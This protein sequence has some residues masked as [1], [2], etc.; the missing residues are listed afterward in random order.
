MKAKRNIFRS[1]DVFEWAMFIIVLFYSLSM[2]TVLFLGLLNSLKTYDDA[3]YYKNFFGL[4]NSKYGWQFQYYTTELFTMF[5]VQPSGSTEYVYMHQMLLNSLLYAVLMSLFTI[6][7]Q[8]MVAYAC[9]KFTFKLNKVLYTT[10]IITMIIPIV[11]SLASEMQVVEFL[12]LR[13][14]IL[15]VC[16]ARCRYSGMYFLVFYAM[17]KSVPWT[18]AEA[19]QIDGAGNLKI[20]LQVMLPL[21][22]STIFA[23]FVLQFINNW[24]DYYTPMLF[25]PQMPTIAY[26]LFVFKNYPEREAPT[27]FKLAASMTTCVPVVILFIIFRNKIM[28]NVS[29]GGIKG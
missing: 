22:K 2:I 26:G 9:A 7:T 5:K 19:A 11:G 6:A 12:G 29:I 23:V 21:V 3:I 16:I 1:M 4:P 18:Y 17:F 24:N 8:V 13:Y 27:T 28:G 20:F 15:G 10:A 14:N 25:I